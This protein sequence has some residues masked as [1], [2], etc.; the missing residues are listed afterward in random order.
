VGVVCKEI[1]LNSPLGIIHGHLIALVR[2]KISLSVSSQGFKT[3][4]LKFKKKYLF[5]SN[6]LLPYSLTHSLTNSLIHSLTHSLT[7]SLACSFTYSFIHSLT[8]SRRELIT[9]TAL[10]LWWKCLE[11]CGKKTSHNIKCLRVCTVF[12]QYY[13]FMVLIASQYSNHQRLHKA[14]CITLGFPI[15]CPN[16]LRCFLIV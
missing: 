14:S 5:I 1:N 3:L 6:F 9:T 13:F 15:M 12:L 10:L 8:H 2:H 11:F 16:T 7:H 4:W